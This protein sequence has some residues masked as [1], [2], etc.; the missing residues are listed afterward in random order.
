MTKSKKKRMINQA[1]V[2]EDKVKKGCFYCE[3]RHK[4]CLDYHHLN[5]TQ[6]KMCISKAINDR[7]LGFIKRKI[8]KCIVLC[9]NCHK[10][11]HYNLRMKENSKIAS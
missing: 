4:A 11:L 5:R 2:D 3:E 9:S 7:T 1:F 6:K 10:K 8:E